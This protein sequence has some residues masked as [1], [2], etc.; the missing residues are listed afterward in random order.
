MWSLLR[1]AV[2][3]LSNTTLN[4]P[5]SLEHSAHTM[6]EAQVKGKPHLEGHFLY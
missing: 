4:I 5:A 6:K 3:L 1:S 2:S